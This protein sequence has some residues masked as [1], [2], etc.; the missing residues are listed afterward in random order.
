MPDSALL[1]ICSY[2]R[3]LELCLSHEA[4]AKLAITMLF[5]CGCLGASAYRQPPST[6]LSPVHGRSQADES[7]SVKQASCRRLAERSCGGSRVGRRR[8]QCSAAHQAQPCADHPV[9]SGHWGAPHC[10]TRK[11]SGPKQTPEHA[12]MPAQVLGQEA[13]CCT[14]LALNL[15]QCQNQLVATCGLS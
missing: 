1:L 13:V 2:R 15:W 8:H 14:I 4:A 7:H 5:T 11:A 3:L 12:I 6:I 9:C 10:T